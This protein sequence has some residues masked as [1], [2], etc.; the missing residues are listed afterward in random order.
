[1][2]NSKRNNKTPDCPK[3]VEGV[4]VLPAEESE[5]TPTDQAESE[6]L[7]LEDVVELEPELEDLPELDEKTSSAVVTYDA[8]RAYLTEVAQH[9]KLSKEDEYALAVR[10]KEFGDREAAYKLTVGNLWLVVAL[11]RRYQRAAR[12]L[13][14]LIQE[15]NI[16]LME[17]V[18]NFDPYKEVRFPAYATWWIKAYIVRFVIANWRMVKLGTTQ[19][20]RKLFFNLEKEREKLERQ[21][22]VPTAKLLAD[23]L[24]VKESEVVE[25]Q[26]R[27]GGGDVSVDAPLAGENDGNLHGILSSGEPSLEDSLASKEIQNRLREAMAE[28]ANSLNSKE[29]SIYEKRL[30]AEEKSTLQELALEYSISKERVRQI[31]NRIKDRLKAYVAEKLGMDFLVDELG[32]ED[33]KVKK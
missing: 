23:N 29:R 17:A 3:D 21:G 2:A 12:S 33:S 6:E 5:A 9:P 1:M 27:L 31:E 19:A 7:D 25:M 30:L 32:V 11:A 15:G 20:Q 24:N 26:Q 18:K 28:F 22:F 13:L 4:E 16:G 8:L 14:D 10:Y